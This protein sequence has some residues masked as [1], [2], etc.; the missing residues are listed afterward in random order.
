MHRGDLH[1]GGWVCLIGSSCCSHLR[2]S[3][4]IAIDAA[5]SVVLRQQGALLDVGLAAH[6]LSAAAQSRVGYSSEPERELKSE[7]MN[8]REIWE[9][10]DGKVGVGMD[11]SDMRGQMAMDTV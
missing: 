5:T 10:A 1:R 4:I 9:D 7:Q 11:A 2:A 6:I 8:W 3:V